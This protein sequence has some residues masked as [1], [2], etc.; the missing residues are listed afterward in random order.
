MQH[1]D[2]TILNSFAC[3]L[4]VLEQVY[5]SNPD[6]IIRKKSQLLTVGDLN[7][8]GGWFC[9][10]CYQPIDIIRRLHLDSKLLANKKS[11]TE[12]LNGNYHRKPIINIEFIQNLI[13]QGTY[14]DGRTT[15]EKLRPYDNEKYFVPDCVAKNRG[16]FSNVVSNFYASWDDSENEGYW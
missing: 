7:H 11:S 15:L 6:N 8:F 14:I 12:L 4:N 13:Q 3:Q 5:K 9:E 10:Y 2:K 16:K 1:P